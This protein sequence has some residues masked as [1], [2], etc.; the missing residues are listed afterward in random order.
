MARCPGADD[1]SR[2]NPALAYALASNWVFHRPAVTRPMRAA[3]SLVGRAEPRILEWLGF[4]TS[5]P[6][7]RILAKIVPL[8]LSV[9]GLLYLRDALADPW[10]VR[11][12]SHLR[13]I[14]QGALRLTTDPRL[15]PHVTFR[16]I[17]DV[18]RDN[19]HDRASGNGLQPFWGVL[20]AV[21]RLGRADDPLRFLSWEHLIS[22][23]DEMVA[24][25]EGKGPDRVAPPFVG[26]DE[27]Q[28]IATL[29]D[30][31]AGDSTPLGFHFLVCQFESGAE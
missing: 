12:L 18:S 24:W 14:N 2:S 3:R 15:R 10:T 23:H 20:R 16:L 19:A 5:E 25:W 17:E 9:E 11:I 26:D 30:P 13:R 29:W 21:R 31:S 4:P 7:R 22:M 8:S 1:L 6:A 27:I 28:P